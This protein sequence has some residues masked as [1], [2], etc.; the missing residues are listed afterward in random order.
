MSQN[1][2]LPSKTTVKVNAR[3]NSTPEF[4]SLVDE[5]KGILEIVPGD[6]HRKPHAIFFMGGKYVYFT[7]E[8]FMD[9]IHTAAVKKYEENH[10]ETEV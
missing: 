9:T 3:M 10:K 1:V 2:S 8:E 6:E 4:V 7:L 5:N